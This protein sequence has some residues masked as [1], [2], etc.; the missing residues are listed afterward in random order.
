MFCGRSVSITT[1][2]QRGQGETPFI[3]L[4][5]FRELMGVESDE[6]VL[7]KALNRKVIKVAIE[8]DQQSYRIS[9]RS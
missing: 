5:V 8:G 2:R 7:F 4:E 9:R 3:P 6:Y 1:I